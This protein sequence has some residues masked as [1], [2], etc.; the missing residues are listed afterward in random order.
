MSIVELKCNVYLKLREYRSPAI[1]AKMQSS[2]VS[3][4]SLIYYI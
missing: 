3:F 4:S 1:R 2:T